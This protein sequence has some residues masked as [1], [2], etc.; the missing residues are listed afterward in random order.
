MQDSVSLLAG[1]RER[2]RVLDRALVCWQRN[3]EV[4][5]MRGRLG[6]PNEK[7]HLGIFM[8]R[9]VEAVGSILND[10]TG[11]GENPRGHERIVIHQ[12]EQIGTPTSALSLSHHARDEL[13]LANRNN[14]SPP[15]GARNLCVHLP[16]RNQAVNPLAEGAESV[17]FAWNLAAIH[18]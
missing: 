17:G 15:V 13:M 9:R 16:S 1:E 2:F 5:P 7:T 14:R 12:H 18:S 3:L 4:E 8:H 11:G 10:R 6:R